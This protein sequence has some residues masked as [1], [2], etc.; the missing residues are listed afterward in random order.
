METSEI[1]VKGRANISQRPDCIKLLIRVKAQSSEYGVTM[2]M[3]NEAVQQALEA[4]LSVGVDED[5]Q[6]D[7]YA[8]EEDWADPYE[9]SK[10]KFIGYEG[11]Q[12]L[13]VRMPL[14]MTM[15]GEVL[16]E[17]SSLKTKPSV[18]TYFE[19]RDPSKMQAEA[20]HKAI[21]ASRLAADDIAAQLGVN[22]GKVKSVKYDM[23]LS[24][25]SSSLSI[26]MDE[27]LQ[28]FGAPEGKASMPIINPTEIESRDDITIVWSI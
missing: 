25:Q 16:K 24:I 13:A 3:L 12:Q 8:I 9:H 10:R 23:P 21:E 28:V 18:H 19:V 26:D 2:Q 15:L 14:D 11:E 17:L 7:S 6:T 27:A 5:P 22:L 1:I 20:R 4:I